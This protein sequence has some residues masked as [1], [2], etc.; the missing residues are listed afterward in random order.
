[1]AYFKNLG[2]IPQKLIKGQFFLWNVKGL[3]HLKPTAL[4]LLGTLT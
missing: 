2:I 4:T 3:R 1:M